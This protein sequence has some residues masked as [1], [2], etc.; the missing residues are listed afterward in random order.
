MPHSLELASLT[1]RY[2]YRT[3]VG[4]I[5]ID[6]GL[7][8]FKFQFLN[9]SSSEVRSQDHSPRLS[10]MSRRIL[11]FGVVLLFCACFATMV[12]SFSRN[13]AATYDEPVHLSAGYTYWRWHDYR[14]NPEHPPLIKKLAALPGLWR[15]S[16]PAEVDLSRETAISLPATNSEGILR[17][18]WTLSLDATAEE[19]EFAHTFLYGIRPEA[20]RRL[21]AKNPGINRPAAILPT[22]Q[23][24]P[25][26][27]YN[28]ADELLFW[29]RLP[30]LLLGVALAVLVFSWSRQLFGFAGGVLSMALFCFDPSFIA[31]SGLVTTDVGEALFLFGSVYFLWRTCRHWTAANII[32]FLLSFGLAFAAKFSAVLLL[33]I[34]WLAAAGWM[35]SRPAGPVA[36]GDPGPSNPFYARA[37]RLAGLFAAALLATYIIIWASYSFRY[38]AA[39]DPPSAAR[40]ETQLLAESE[41]PAALQVPYRS[42]GQLRIEAAVRGAAALKKIRLDQPGTPLGDEQISQVMASIP[43]GLSGQLIL[44][45]QR[46]ELLP[47]AFI[48]GFA[49]AE[50]GSQ[51]RTSFLLG[52]Y[53][54]AGFRSYFPCAFLLKTPLPALLFILTSLT[55]ALACRRNWN[56]S[57]PFLI[58]PAGLYFAVAIGSH[59]NI[60]QRHLLP[61]YPFLYVLAGSLAPEWTRFRRPARIITAVATLLAIAVSSQIVFSP[62]NHQKWQRVAPHYLAYFNELAGGPGKGYT[63][64]VDSNLDWGQD[65]KELKHWLEAS[66]LTEPMYLCY[67][68]TADPRYHG[69]LHY[70]LPGGYRFEPQQGF[71]TLKPGG[72]IAISATNLQGVYLSLA[73]RETWRQILDHSVPVG[74]VGY[75]IF[76]YRFT[77]FDLPVQGTPGPA[78][79]N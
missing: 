52:E 37:G 53:S 21:Q 26:D 8:W 7:G 47:E 44:F 33:P 76:L 62:L 70:N 51:M 31:H 17:R 27:F 11:E 24:V 60:G 16:W 78:A 58:A 43:V 4:N 57:L 19:D 46:H 42:M 32:L 63:E 2:R 67:F 28:N 25:Q 9:K 66:N 22:A 35:L 75:S 54:S 10:A 41:G 65:L 1:V 56:W 30:V 6:P 3:K 59:I 20:F 48:Y 45:V 5:S 74:T 13:S 38:S 23:L 79:A 14:L 61:I 36:P 69:I 68:G 55:L 50:M 12:I 29:G 73:D 49:R 71:D 34:F 77:G 39:A 15:Q 40:A 72:L 18:T 64:L